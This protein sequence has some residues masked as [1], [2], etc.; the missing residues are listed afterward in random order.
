M[1]SE[2]FEVRCF[3]CG[4][5]YDTLDAAWCS[6]LSAARTL[7]CPHCLACFCKAPNQFRQEFWA[8]APQ[9]LWERRAQLAQRKEEILDRRAKEPSKAKRP[10]ILIVDDEKEL[11]RV[12][13][14]T[15]EELGYGF[16][17]ASDGAAGLELA[18]RFLPDLILTDALMP[19]LDGR[20]MCRLLKLDPA[21]A[22]IKIVVMT[23]LYT[24]NRYR[25]EGISQFRADD[26]LTKP[27]ELRELRDLLQKHTG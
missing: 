13:A 14:E 20:E 7:I 23:G 3:H 17:V 19:R 27:L 8:A 15:V 11:Q 18:K 25:V 16:L 6:C 5:V 9:S 4:A 2:H 1:S 21:T 12:M 10:L 26:Y 24:G 22:H